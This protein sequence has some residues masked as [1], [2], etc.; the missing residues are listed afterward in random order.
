METL[1]REIQAWI[2]ENFL[3]VRTMTEG[4]SQLPGVMRVFKQ[5]FLPRAAGWLE[6]SKGPLPASV[7][8]NSLALGLE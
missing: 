6:D 2:K 7:F 3:A 8:Y 5:W 4:V 1:Q